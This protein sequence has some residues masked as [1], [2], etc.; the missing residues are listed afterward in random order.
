MPSFE[1]L[2]YSAFKKKNEEKRWDCGEGNVITVVIIAIVVEVVPVVVVVV[3]E[4]EPWRIQCLFQFIP[5]QAF[6][7]PI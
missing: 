2:Q 6:L 4:I 1:V 3:V 7:T 5:L